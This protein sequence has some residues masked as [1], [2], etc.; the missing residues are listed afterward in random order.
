MRILLQPSSG[1]EA[2]GHFE[3]TIDGGL[4]LEFF[5]EKVT[6]EQYNR[7]SQS[8]NKKIRV[9]GMVPSVDNKPKKVWLDLKENDI[10][11]FYAKKKF[12]YGA[13]VNLKFIIRN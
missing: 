13:I 4:A 1:K 3:D 8:T 11:L 9:W 10:V 5:E 6:P 2:T 7:L 12:F